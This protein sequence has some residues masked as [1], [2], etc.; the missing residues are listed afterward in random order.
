MN[1]KLIVNEH[2]FWLVET[3]AEACT[4]IAAVGISN[5]GVMI[6]S[7]VMK[8]RYR[9]KLVCLMTTS[10]LDASVGGGVDYW[11]LR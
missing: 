7:E 4:E 9:M 10:T 3:K 11:R 6:V 2:G 8:A 1:L 5:S